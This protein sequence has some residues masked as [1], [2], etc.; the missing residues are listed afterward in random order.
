MVRE[1][2]LCDCC[3]TVAVRTRSTHNAYMHNSLQHMRNNGP[4]TRTL[5]VCVALSSSS[6]Q[7]KTKANNLNMGFQYTNPHAPTPAYTY[8]NTHNRHRY[9]IAT[10][11]AG[12]NMGHGLL[13]ATH[14]SLCCCCGSALVLVKV[15]VLLLL[16][17]SNAWT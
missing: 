6:K 11:Y 8:H 5:V 4:Q 3:C 2:L 1:N 15:E 7:S 13:H 17:P 14:S 9:T 10:V 16:C 12:G